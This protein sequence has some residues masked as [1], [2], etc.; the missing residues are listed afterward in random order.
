MKPSHHI[1]ISGCVSLGY[2][3]AM[4]SWPATVGCFLSGVL[5]DIDHYWE[6]YVHRKKFPFRYKDLV[7]FC[8]PNK[9]GK[10]Y[11]IFHAYEYLLAFWLL[12]YMLH[13]GVVWVGIALGLTVHLILDQI[14]NPI[15]PLF[16]FMAYRIKHGFQ[17]SKI[18]ELSKFSDKG[19]S[20]A[21][22]V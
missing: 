9:D 14:F 4:H 13:L 11:L 10:L 12:I 21:P 8:V 1:I 20:V 6:Y 16:F 3:A 22:T 18:L 15:K 2:H 17:K 5:I 19:N 7:D